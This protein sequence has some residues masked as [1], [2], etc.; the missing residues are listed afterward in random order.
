MLDIKLTD[1]QVRQEINQISEFIAQG[2]GSR[3]RVVIGVSGGLDSDVVVR[4]AKFT[5]AIKK[6]KLFIVLQHD[7][8]PKHLQNARELAEDLKEELIE[9]PLDKEPF[10]IIETLE[11]ADK[12]E[13]FHVKGLDAMRMKCSLRNCV[14]SAYQDHGYIVLGTGNRTEHETGFYLPFGDGVSHLCPIR[15]LYKTQVRQLAPVLGTLEPVI[16]QPA[17]AG[18]WLGEE[19]IEDLAWWLFNEKPITSDAKFGDEDD[20]LVERIK[21]QLTTEKID[22]ILFGLYQKIN[23]DSIS[24]EIGIS[25]DVIVK[26]EKLISASDEFKNRAYNKQLPKRLSK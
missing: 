5:S 6:M 20:A 2:L 7:M 18:F 19:D 1:V 4:I 15:H 12:N 24:S 22:Q 8:D 3:D 26:F 16:S 17:S 25:S 13:M 9:L 23:A 21:N 14:I 10:I 11:K